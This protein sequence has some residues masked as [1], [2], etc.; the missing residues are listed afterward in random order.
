M[1]IEFRRGAVQEA[2]QAGLEDMGLRQA[3]K[4]LCIKQRPSANDDL[5]VCQDTSEEDTLEE[6]RFSRFEEEQFHDR[7]KSRRAV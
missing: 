3:C 6:H 7:I 1:H 4:M 2:F 5:K